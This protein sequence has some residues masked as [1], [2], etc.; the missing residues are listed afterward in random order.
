ME[1][2]YVAGDKHHDWLKIKKF[3][4]FDLAVLGAYMEGDTISQLLCGTYNPLENRY[5]TL[6]K[7]N[8]RR[9]GIGEEVKSKV[10]FQKRKP[11]SVC[12]SPNI[13]EDEVPNLYVNPERSV[14][15]EVKAMKFSRDT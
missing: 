11:S 14:V 4:T 7:V 1:S 10:R 15:V 13:K 2:L 3:E 12:L 5:E 6:A 9:E 8:A